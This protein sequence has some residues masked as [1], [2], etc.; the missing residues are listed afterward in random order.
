MVLPDSLFQVTGGAI[1]GL[2]WRGIISGSKRFSL[3]VRGCSLIRKPVHHVNNVLYGTKRESPV[4][5]VCVW[6]HR[7]ACKSPPE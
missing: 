4:Q 1:V 6:L 7:R 2:N 3:A 5:E